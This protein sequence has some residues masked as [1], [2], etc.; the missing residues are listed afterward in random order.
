M[1]YF[2]IILL[3]I[4]AG[5][6]L[7][8]LWV[9][10]VHTIFSL[11]GTLVGLFI[12]SRYYEPMADWLMGVT[13]WSGNFSKVLMF[14]VAFILIA[15]LVSIVFWL[16]EKVLG[17]FTK[18]PIVSGINHIL[19]GLFG[20]FEGVIILGIIFF[21]I[22]RF[23][24]GQNFMNMVDNSLVVPYLVQPIKILM[25]LIPNAVKYLQSTVKGVF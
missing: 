23:P 13:G 1:S 14:I 8:G 24:V 2:D 10:L 19:G 22:A 17:I 11:L 4:V 9:G 18:L 20:L 7:F 16:L 21:F 3:A 6:G 5:F 15:K 12:A 25:P